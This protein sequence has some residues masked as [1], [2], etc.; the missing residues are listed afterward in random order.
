MKEIIL[1]DT[2]DIRTIALL[3]NGQL[4]EIYEEDKS[5]KLLDGNIYCGVVRNIL[6]GMQ[7][8]FVD[9]GE[10]KNAFI[11][12]K[13]LI[14]K[15]SDETGNKCEKMSKYDIN[16]YIKPKMRILVQ[17]KKEEEHQKGAKI[18]TN[19]NLP[20]RYT[21]IMPGSNFITV[22]QKIENKDETIRLK[23]IVSDELKKIAEIDFGVIIRTCAVGVSKEDLENDIHKLV[24]LWKNILIEFENAKEH[25]QPVPIYISPD[26]T[27]KL[28][29]GTVKSDE[30]R[31]YANTSDLINS[32]QTVLDGFDIQNVEIIKKDEGLLD[33][34]DLKEQ[35][36]KSKQRK[37]WLK[38]GGFITIDKTE[39]LT[40]IDV[41]SGKFIGKKTNTKD[42]T[43]FDVNKEATV[44]I[45]RQL[46]LKNISGIIVIDYIDMEKE[47]EREGIIN[48]LECELKKDRSKTQVMGFTKLDLL[49][50]TRKRI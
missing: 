29:I 4:V 12:I 31:I 23:K 40:A 15:V 7:S 34:Y 32:V 13:D 49:E 22:S 14:P 21:I 28:I 41:N 50:M 18:S 17:V 16:D 44:E 1:N 27:Q 33:L 20:G 6:P 36:E 25:Q 38:S 48:I 9:I 2:K 39:A 8:A 37:I 3:E 26:T 30:C 19:I 24:N 10:R 45:A 47:S 42:D 35:I 5:K 46:R 11:H 43:I